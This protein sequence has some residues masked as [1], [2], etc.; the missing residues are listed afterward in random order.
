MPGM[1][2]RA[3]IMQSLGTSQCPC[4]WGRITV[5]QETESLTFPNLSSGLYEPCRALSSS[6]G[7]N[8]CSQERE[9]AQPLAG[10]LPGL[11]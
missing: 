6:H 7:A 4:T 11:L 10:Q 9:G 2:Q 8:C 3:G 5:A 1:G